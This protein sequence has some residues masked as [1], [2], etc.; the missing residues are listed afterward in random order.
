MIRAIF[1]YPASSG[2]LQ[3]NKKQLPIKKPLDQERRH[4]GAIRLQTVLVNILAAC[5]LLVKRLHPPV[6][7]GALRRVEDATIP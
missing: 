5:D 1:A 4:N 7:L 6:T 2:I 3:P